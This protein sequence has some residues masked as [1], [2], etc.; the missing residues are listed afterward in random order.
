MKCQQQ[1]KHLFKETKVLF[2][3]LTNKITPQTHPII[4]K[5]KQK[6]WLLLIKRIK[7]IIYAWIT[8]LLH[9]EITEQYLLLPDSVT[10]ESRGEIW[11]IPPDFTVNFSFSHSLCGS[12]RLPTDLLGTHYSS[13]AKPNLGYLHML[14]LPLVTVQIGGNYCNVN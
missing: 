14:S 5:C 6:D 12:I 10:K 2:Y 7:T 11:L 3:L 13:Q 1:N 4:L 8:Q 9:V